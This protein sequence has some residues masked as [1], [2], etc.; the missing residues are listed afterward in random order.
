MTDF[1]HW[2]HTLRA[3]LPWARIRWF[4][5]LALAFACYLLIMVVWLDA[6]SK[7]ELAGIQAPLA[8]ELYAA[9]GQLIGKYY[10]ENR[11]PLVSGDLNAFYRHALIAT[12]DIRFYEHEGIDYRSLGR[13]LIK[14]L[15]LQQ[16]SS[17]GGSTISQQLAKNL[18]PRKDYLI[19]DQLCNKYREMTIALR[20]EELYD[21]EEI[22]LLY[23]NTVSFGERAF[24][25]RTAAK[26]FFN[27]EPKDLRLEEAAT[28]VVLL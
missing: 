18:Y 26:R 17:G 21:K 3:R 9:D 13:V 7:K 10:V 25:L 24:G 27:K 19:F 8:S 11:S 4:L 28:L 1:R 22:L 16:E 6:P 2:I 15:L 14:T 23:S 20:L 5:L 12:E